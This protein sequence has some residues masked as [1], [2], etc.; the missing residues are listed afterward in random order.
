MPAQKAELS[1]L[2]QAKGKRVNIY[3]DSKS[4][5]LVLRA[6]GAIWKEHGLL[7]AGKKERKHTSEI[8]HLLE[9]VQEPTQVAVMHCVGRHKG[10][11]QLT[12]GNRRAEFTAKEAAHLDTVMALISMRDLQ[13]HPP[14]YSETDLQ[15]AAP[16]GATH[17]VVPQGPEGQ[18]GRESLH[19]RLTPAI[20]CPRNTPGHALWERCFT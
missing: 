20:D 7:T 3:T 2:K 12:T 1:A 9:A 8:L 11:D 16:T 17:K 14:A 15:E 5:F 18:L 4:A 6:H 13:K 10:G 19:P